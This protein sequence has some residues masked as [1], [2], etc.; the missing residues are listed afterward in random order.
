M[1]KEKGKYIGYLTTL[2][3]STIVWSDDIDE[4]KGIWCFGS[5]IFESNGIDSIKL[6]EIFPEPPHRGVILDYFKNNLKLVC[7]DGVMIGE[8]SQEEIR[9][10]KMQELLKDKM[11]K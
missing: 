7:R 2:E 6:K 10:L 8:L 4:I 11:N 9:F 3:S 5:S 1:N